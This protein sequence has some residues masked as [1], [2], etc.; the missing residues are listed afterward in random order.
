MSELRDRKEPK[1]GIKSYFMLI[2]IFMF[3]KKNKHIII[4]IAHSV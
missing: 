1:E 3:S 4:I 2:V